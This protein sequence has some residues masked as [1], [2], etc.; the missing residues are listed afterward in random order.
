M[1]CACPTTPGDCCGC[2]CCEDAFEAAVGEGATPPQPANRSRHSL[3]AVVGD[4]E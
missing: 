3:L 1:N 2:S 4:R